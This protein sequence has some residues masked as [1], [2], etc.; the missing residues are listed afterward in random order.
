MRAAM[1][2]ALGGP[3]VLTLVE[4]PDPVPAKGEVIVRVRAA[5]VHPADIAARVGQIPG[6]PVPPPFMPGWDIA[7]EIVAT[8]AEVTEFAAGEQVAGM[9]PWYLTRGSIGAYAELVA[10]D[11]D[12]LVPI[13]PGLDPIAAATVPLNG[14]TA[15]RALDMM[16]LTEPTDVLV[17]GA[18]GGVGGFAAQLATQQGHSVYASATHDDED[19]VRGLGVHTVVPRSAQL[20]TA[21]VVLD[22]VPLGEPAG[23]AARPGGVLLSTRPTP[24][25]DPAKRVRQEVVL[26]Q[27]DRP[28]LRQLLESVAKDQLRTRVAATFPLAEAAEAHRRFEAGA[29][30]GKIVL[31]P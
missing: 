15:R 11:P 3:E 31:V 24:P 7:G 30:R 13:P 18:S 19:W 17:T 14:L 22:A 4:R 1:V 20:P 6:G 8:G 9:I 21:T 25:V 28:A 27:L 2:T 10:A 29:V 16:A 26:V 12:W 23:A 5:C